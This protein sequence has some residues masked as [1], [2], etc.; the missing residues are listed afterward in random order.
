MYQILVTLMIIWAFAAGQNISDITVI[1]N[2]AIL[3]LSYGAGRDIH[4]LTLELED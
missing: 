2:T 4:S 3:P 1:K